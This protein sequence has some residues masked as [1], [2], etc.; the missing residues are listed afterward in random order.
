MFAYKQLYNNKHNDCYDAAVVIENNFF[1]LIK[2]KQLH[3][4]KNY[5]CLKYLPW[6]EYYNEF[7]HAITCCFWAFQSYCI[8]LR[9]PEFS[10][11]CLMVMLLSSAIFQQIHYN[12]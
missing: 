12:H 7:N 5:W 2:L 8:I 4:R 6:K 9:S 10:K 1:I 3:I 11:K